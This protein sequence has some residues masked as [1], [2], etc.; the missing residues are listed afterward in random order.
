MLQTGRQPDLALEALGAETRGQLGVEDLERHR[1]VVPEILRE[2]H[3]GHAAP[4]DLSLEAVAGGQL[5]LE[6][7][8]RGQGTPYGRDA[9]KIG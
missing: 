3:R 7:R 5:D 8:E 9:E 1:P 4:A 6:R 2:I